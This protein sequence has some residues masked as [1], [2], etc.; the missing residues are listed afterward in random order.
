[1]A[2]FNLKDVNV[3]I[4]RADD[5][6]KIMIFRHE[7]GEELLKMNFPPVAEIGQQWMVAER[8]KEIVGV[9]AVQEDSRFRATDPKSGEIFYAVRKDMR[10]G[11]VAKKL[12]RE[13]F[14][15]CRELGFRSIYGKPRPSL[16]REACER[17]RREVGFGSYTPERGWEKI[18]KP[19][20]N[21][22]KFFRNAARRIRKLKP[23]RKKSPIRRR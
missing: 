16:S 20:G 3:R 10:G 6:R 19:R 23:G 21:V 5:F 13:M 1:M 14:K 22:S 11:G 2:N 9:C 7:L 15:N 4:A 8:G 17:V 18:F 12:V